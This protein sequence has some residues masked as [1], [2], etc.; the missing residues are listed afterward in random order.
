M[1]RAFGDTLI[2]IG[3]L[4]MLLTVLVM[5]DDR[6]REA[7][8][9]QFAGRTP[10]GELTNAGYHARQIAGVVFEAARYHTVEH[11]PMMIFA[12]VATVLTLFMLRT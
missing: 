3:A 6:V 8:S 5:V 10:S 4:A 12:L 7:V 2:S 1:R 9:M 11:A